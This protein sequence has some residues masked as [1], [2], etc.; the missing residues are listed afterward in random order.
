MF[1]MQEG[2]LIIILFLMELNTQWCISNVNECGPEKRH[3]ETTAK[4]F[5]TP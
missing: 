3:T 4:W 2:R 5:D 1:Q